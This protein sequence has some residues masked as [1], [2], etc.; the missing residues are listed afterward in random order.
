MPELNEVRKGKEIPFG[1]GT[2]LYIWTS[3][4][5]CGNCR[6]VLK[7]NHEKGKQLRCYQCAP[8]HLYSGH[9]I[10][11]SR[12]LL[13]GYVLIGLN[14]DS[15]YYQMRNK[16]GYVLEHRF[17]M[18]KHLGRCLE[19]WEIVHHI[20]GIKTDNRIENLLLANPIEHES[21]TILQNEVK[22]LKANI[23]LLEHRLALL[24]S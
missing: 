23:L 24:E 9:E 11:R 16:L 7:R 12:R 1:K 4:I 13:N 22:T 21:V 15:P 5:D 6:W 18:A 20:N 8:K 2:D 3:C 10:I 14:K 19:S 17:I